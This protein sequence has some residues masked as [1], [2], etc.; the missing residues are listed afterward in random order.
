MSFRVWMHLDVGDCGVLF[1]GNCGLD[2]DRGSLK[3]V[4]RAYLVTECH[5]LLLGHFDPAL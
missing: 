2:L 3:I 4:H 5:I 1:W